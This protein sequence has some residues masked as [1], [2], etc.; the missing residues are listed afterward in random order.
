M[1]DCR[2]DIKLVLCLTDGACNDASLGKEICTALRGK[3]E[4]IGILLEPD[5]VTKS[6][7]TDMFGK[8]KVIACRSKELPIKLGNILRAIRGV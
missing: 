5:D 4:V 1:Q 8:D 2:E 6:Y 7:L 3:V